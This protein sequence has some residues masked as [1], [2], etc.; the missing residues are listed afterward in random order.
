MA[1]GLVVTPTGLQYTTQ[2]Q[3]A[4]GVYTTSNGHSSLTDVT[5][6]G[7]QTGRLQYV[8]AGYSGA[9]QLKMSSTTGTWYTANLSGQ[10]GTYTQYN[11]GIAANAFDYVPLDATFTNPSIV[12]GDAAA[13]R[14]DAYAIDTNGNPVAGTVVHLVTSE[15][16]IG[17]GVARDPVSGDIL[18]TT[19][20]NDI[21]ALS[22]SVP[23]PGTVL[24]GLSGIL[25]LWRRRFVG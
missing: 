18:F 24:L 16:G 25:L 17:Y 5:S 10:P 2:S 11:P 7:A 22:D 4:L 20:N 21:W 13:G 15:V 3:S 14:L 1:G 12:L 19:Q 23:E 8:P 6:T 9:G